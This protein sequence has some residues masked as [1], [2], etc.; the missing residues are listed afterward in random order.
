[1]QILDK[2]MNPVNASNVKEAIATMQG[3]IHYMQES[4]EQYGGVASKKTAE[5]QKLLE[6]TQ[7]AVASL[8]GQME[9][10]SGLVSGLEARVTQLEGSVV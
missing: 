3:Y 7:G 4:F 2:Q 8:G 6:T 5:M 9:A 10:L 1:M